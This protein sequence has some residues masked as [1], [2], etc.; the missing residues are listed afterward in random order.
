MDMQVS[1][2]SYARLVLWDRPIFFTFLVG[3]MSATLCT[4]SLLNLDDLTPFER[5][6]GGAIGLGLVWVL[7]AKMPFQ[8]FIFDRETG[9]IYR[10]RWKLGVRF[11]D[12]MSLHRITNVRQ[13]ADRLGDSGPTYV[14]T[15]E[16][17]S[18]NGG[19]ETA[20]LSASSTANRHDETIETLN[21]WLS[22]PEAS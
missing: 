10:T 12:C 5:G 21:E 11:D 16:Y 9:L 15:I 22:R 1:H 7:W 19:I 3:S 6:I 4:L 17:E 20:R 8:R 2:K 14:I 18:Q 13:R